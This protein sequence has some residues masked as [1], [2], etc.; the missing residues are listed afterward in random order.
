MKP[1]RDYQIKAINAVKKELDNGVKKQ[2][3]VMATGTG[4][5][6]TAVKAIEQFNFQRVL[7]ITHTEELVQQSALAF[8]SEKFDKELTDAVEDI[9][10]IN[11]VHNGSG[12]FG[13]RGIK[14]RMGLIKADAFYPDGSVVMASAQTLYR[15]LDKLPKDHFDAIVCDECFPKGTLV[16][17][18]HI[19]EIKVG[20]IVNSF[21]HDTHKTEKKKVVRLFKKEIKSD[22][23]KIKLENGIEFICTE[24]HPIYTKELGYISAK[25]ICKKQLHCLYLQNDK[26]NISKRNKNKLF[27]LFKRNIDNKKKQ[28]KSFC[29][30]SKSVLFGFLQSR[31][32]EKNDENLFSKLQ[33]LRKGIIIYFKKRKSILLGGIY[34]LPNIFNPERRFLLEKE[35]KG[36]YGCYKKENRLQESFRENEEKQSNVKSRNQTKNDSIVERKNFFIKGRKWTINKTSN[37]VTF[38]NRVRYGISYIYKKCDRFISKFTDLLQSGFSGSRTETCNRSGWKDTQTKE[39]EVFRQE[40]NRDFKFVRVASC[41]IY[42]RRDRDECGES[43]EKTYVYNIEVEDNHNYFVENTLVHNC[44]LFLSRTFSDPL[45]YFEP[46]LLLGLTATPTRLDGMQLGNMFDKIVY[47]YDI[48]DGV[49]DGYLCELDA[50]RI[51]TD[52]SLDNVRTTGGEFNAKDLSNEVDIPQRN[53]LIVDSYKTYAEGRQGIFFCVDIKH[54]LHLAEEFKSQGIICNAVSSDEESTGDRSQAIKDFKAGKIQVLTN[55]G[56][57]T[58]GFDHRNTGVIGN[59]APTKSLSKYLQCIGRGTRLK[60]ENFVAKY[61]Q[62]CVILD[63]VDSTTRHKLINAWSLDSGKATEEKVFMTKAKKKALIDERER[64]IAYVVATS[65]KDVKVDLFALPKVY[66]SNSIKME[67]PATEKQLAWIA[68]LGYDTVNV[69]YTKKMCSEI[70]SAQPATEKQ[71]GLLKWKG[72]DVSNGVTISEFKMAIAEIEKRENKEVVNKYT[73]NN[74]GNPFF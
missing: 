42:Q 54:S 73:P 15:R 34:I 16:D 52:L 57:L 22:L 48:A 58:T 13:C 59:C 68:R 70:I 33:K 40:K 12:M 63:F 32:M 19:E 29:S 24:E 11:W 30:I 36:G 51:K 20:D 18:K 55:V 47:S 7:W 2:L 17:G 10:F 28:Y 31:K 49:K 3:L 9:G 8:L 71:I 50:V 5:T 27:N 64:K 61:G 23:Y 25:S 43:C 53:K 39:M 6:F 4:K 62:N 45:K 72:Y 56:I 41:E 67:E 65:K 21:N 35:K 38:S 74:N 1:L 60:D 44:H 37:D 46:K 69:E 14:F 26:T 66:I